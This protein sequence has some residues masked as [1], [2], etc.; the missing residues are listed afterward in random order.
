M[1]MNFLREKFL[2]GRMWLKWNVTKENRASSA[3]RFGDYE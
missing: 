1:L 2:E 3:D